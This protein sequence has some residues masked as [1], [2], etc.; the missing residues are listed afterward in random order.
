MP[1]G[2]VAD[3]QGA[4][5][6]MAQWF[7]LKAEHPDALLF[8][9][10]GDFFEMFFA[11][12]DAA[13][14]ALD[15]ALTHRGEHNGTPIQ[16]C[17]VPVANA[18]LYLA[19][20]IR[21]GFR[22]A[23]AEQTE[24]AS[25]RIGKGPL[26]RAIVRLVTPG[27][28]T[29]ESLLEAGQTNLLLALSGAADTVGA[30]WLDMSTGLFE[31]ACVTAATLPALLGRL[32][33]AE[34]LAPDALDL[35]DHA[36]RR[37]PPMASPAPQA[38]RRRLAEAF[39]AASLDAFGS[40]T[41]AEACAGALALD[42]VK[43]TQAGSMPRLSRPVPVGESSQMAMDAATRASLELLRAR[44]GGTA[45]TLLASV[46][47]TTSAPGAR[48]L[49]RWVAAPLTDPAV[50]ARRQDG[51]VFLTAEPARL[52]SLRQCLRG[53][54][55]LARALGRLSLGRGTPR[56]LASVRLGLNAAAACAALL[57]GSGPA[58][59]V[60]ARAALDAA[61]ALSA[62]LA[63]ALAD[64]PPAR[65]EDGGAVAPGYDGE[66]DAERALRDDSR[67]VIA[68]LQM[69]FS[70]RFGV[71][72]LKIKHH[73]Q[74]GYVVEAPSPAV[75]ALRA[76]RELTL[77][78]GMA[79]GA[80][81]THPEL[82]D[83]DRRITEAAD[84]AQARER[85][86]F[87]TLVAATLAEADADRG[88]SLGFGPARRAAILR[89]P[90]RRRRLVPAGADR[91]G[92]VLHQRRPA[93]GGGRGR[94]GLSA[95]RPFG[96]GRLRAQRLRPFARTPRA[97][98]DRPQHGGQIDLPAAERADCHFGPDR[99]AGAG[100]G[101]QTWH[102]R[103]PVQPGGGGRRAGARSQ[104]L[105]GRDDRDGR[106]PAPGRP[107]Q[108]GDRG[109]DRPRHSNPG[110]PGHR[111]GGAGGAAQPDT[112]PHH[113]RHTLPR[114]GAVDRNAA[115]P[116]PTHDAGCASGA[117]TWSSCTRWPRGRPA[118]AGACRWPAWPACPPWW[119]AAP[120]RCSRP[121]SATAPLSLQTCRCL[122]PCRSRLR[123]S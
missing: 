9:R 4:S 70:Q 102:R 44:D 32:D 6:A 115:P 121:W 55:D 80:R 61:P 45:L 119:C 117:A 2:A 93:P 77:R 110:R 58:V 1:L 41:D 99:P 108:P 47:R 116:A 90:G 98:A 37:A 92:R 24:A 100:G 97:A 57:D 112:L 19:R 10:M 67:R 11:D 28:L 111:L 81:F 42:Y 106:D 62:L 18:D 86:V 31:T 14:S 43:L 82:S 59:L 51:W 17:G 72:S 73:A 68:T 64:T 118:E 120:P 66:L 75:E 23:I 53:A 25:A 21:R 79:N 40:F 39:G 52:A 94:G 49:A 69:D 12:A 88:R 26:K 50:I 104:H 107:A 95:R 89:A 114:A 3:A 48:L 91:D 35:G 83:L 96:R 36:T 85:T 29:E 22:V 84:R 7:A 46:N 16:M 78:Q 109:R 101:G 60:Q 27:T 56:D 105:H 74:L 30:A 8:F 38:A 87:A 5:P 103:S 54:P 63:Q 33:P 123:T 122:R 20:L 113:L 65:L 15:I 71:A 34:I 76:H 13:S